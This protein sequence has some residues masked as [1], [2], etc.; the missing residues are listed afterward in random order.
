MEV[1]M[2]S[3]RP[4][5]AE[6]PWEL[7]VPRILP[8][9]SFRYWSITCSFIYFIRESLHTIKF[10]HFKCT[11]QQLWTNIYSSVTTI[12]LKT[13]YLKILGSQYYAYYYHENCKIEAFSLHQNNKYTFFSS[14]VICHSHFA[15]R[16]IF[17]TNFIIFLVPWYIVG[18]LSGDAGR[19]M[20][21]L[22]SI[23]P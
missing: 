4:L 16:S 15:L 20:W 6:I 8:R 14:V 18:M 11:V 7:M 19:P 21:P 3:L 12:T 9:P 23:W 17:G 22:L 5:K 2:V 10:M 1:C 13:E